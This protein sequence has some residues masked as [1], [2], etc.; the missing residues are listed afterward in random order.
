MVESQ[1]QL[2]GPQFV[3]H[4]QRQIHLKLSGHLNCW[5]RTSPHCCGPRLP[6]QSDRHPSCGFDSFSETAD[7]V[8]GKDNT[9]EKVHHCVACMHNRTNLFKFDQGA[10]RHTCHDPGSRSE[11]SRHST[12]LPLADCTAHSGMLL[13]ALPGE[14]TAAA[15]AATASGAAWLGSSSALTSWLTTKLPLM[16]SKLVAVP[17]KTGGSM[18]STLGV[19]AQL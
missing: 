12:A 19:T 10:R 7:D 11:G 15:A 2:P 13:L 18:E 14:R 9:L 16:L 3:A 1:Q 17:S 4:W 6:A 5:S 8:Q